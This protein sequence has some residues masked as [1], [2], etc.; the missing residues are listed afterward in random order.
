MNRALS[1]I[2]SD[3]D[4]DNLDLQKRIN[5]QNKSPILIETNQNKNTQRRRQSLLNPLPVSLILDKKS[6]SAIKRMSMTTDLKQLESS[7]RKMTRENAENFKDLYNI[8]PHEIH[9]RKSYSGY[10]S[11]NKISRKSV[12][13]NNN[14]YST[15]QINKF[16]PQEYFDIDM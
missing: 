5:R 13:V 6:K 9:P 11:P 1:Y 10:N 12:S 4:I 8:P 15:N 7:G 3:N 14:N 2:C 16:N